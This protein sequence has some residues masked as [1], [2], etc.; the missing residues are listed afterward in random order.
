MR[1]G[2]VNL[3]AFVCMTPDWPSVTVELACSP[4]IVPVAGLFIVRRHLIFDISNQRHSDLGRI[5]TSKDVADEMGFHL[6]L[7]LQRISMAITSS[8]T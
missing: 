7:D 3:N 6:H 4:F 5:A 1:H 2:R 8:T